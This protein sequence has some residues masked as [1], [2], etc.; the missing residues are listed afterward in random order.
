MQWQSSIEKTSPHALPVAAKLTQGLNSTL[1]RMDADA[2]GCFDA[3]M[4][5]SHGH[6]CETS[7]GNI[8]WLQDG[9]LHTP[10]LSIGVLEG[11]MR[12]VI[13]ECSPY[14]ICET[15]ATIDMLQKADAVCICN[16]AWG[17][18]AVNI[19]HPIGMKWHSE[20]LAQNLSDAIAKMLPDC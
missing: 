8:F 4:L 11:S 19:L 10:P 1:A 14:P 7:S 9:V 12:A 17:A 16:I 2:H 18:L 3:L 5:D 15:I 20:N 6:I 13:L